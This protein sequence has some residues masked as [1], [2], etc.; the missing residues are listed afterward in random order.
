MLMVTAAHRYCLGRKTYIVGACIEWMTAIWPALEANTQSVILR[1]TIGAIMDGEFGSKAIDEPAWVRF[2]EQAWTRI[3][4][5]Q[6]Q[7]IDFALA[8][9]D[10]PWP[11]FKGVT[12]NA[13]PSV[14]KNCGAYDED[15]G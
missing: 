3:S 6:R 8:H 7:W 9:K 12:H 15:E 4:E 2:S 10:K 1:D 11:L 5:E 14:P 13:A